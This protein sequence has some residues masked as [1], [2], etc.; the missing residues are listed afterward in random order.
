MRRFRDGD[1][2]V[3]VCTTVVEVGIDVPNATV[4]VIEHPERFGL[5]QLHQLRGRVGRGEK[6]SHCILLAASSNV[7]ERL[8]AFT[9]IDDGFEIAELDLA[10]R[11]RGDLLGARQSG[12]IDFKIA[13]FPEDADLLS[14]ARALARAVLDADPTLKQ[15]ENKALRDRALARYPRGE[16]LFRV[17]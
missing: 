13:R 2:Q 12:G 17:G 7:P 16:V 5:A 10:E 6:E 15:R 1:H 4:M 8:R 3:L 14:E 11:G 9:L